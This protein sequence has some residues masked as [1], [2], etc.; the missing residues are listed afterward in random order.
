M[1]SFK[2]LAFF[3]TGSGKILL[4]EGAVS[5]VPFISNRVSEGAIDSL[6]NTII[7]AIRKPVLNERDC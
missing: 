3:I 6:K 1:K 4:S 7:L 2:L 5:R